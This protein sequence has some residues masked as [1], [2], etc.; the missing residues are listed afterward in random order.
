MWHQPRFS[1]GEPGNDP[2]VAPFWNVLYDAGADLILNGHDHDYE[3]FAPQ[4]PSGNRDKDQGIV[5]I[6][7]GTGGG[8]MRDLGPYVAANTGR[9][10]GRSGTPTRRGQAT[11][12][13]A[14]PSHA[15]SGAARRLDRRVRRAGARREARRDAPLGFGR[16]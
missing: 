7:V 9:A 8:E 12:P 3:R 6:V 11:R 15:A 1:S 16:W 13:T 5:E 4:D 10:P 2:T 14:S